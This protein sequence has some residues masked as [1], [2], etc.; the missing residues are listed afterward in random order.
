MVDFQ[1]TSAIA[2]VAQLELCSNPLQHHPVPLALQA[3]QLK[4]V[5]NLQ[6]WG[7]CRRLATGPADTT[8]QAPG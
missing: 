4:L 2:N 6:V 8:L 1:T 7:A 5:F 3:F